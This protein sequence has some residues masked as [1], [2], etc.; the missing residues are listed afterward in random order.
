[1]PIL[2]YVQKLRFAGKS[3]NGVLLEEPNVDM[4]LLQR[5]YRSQ[6]LPNGKRMRMGD[7]IV[8]SD[9]LYPVEVIPVFGAVMDRRI[10]CHNSLEL[11]DL[12]YLNNF[13][14]KEMHH[15]FVYNFA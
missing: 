12:F 1:M 14:D 10:N 7:I 3:D 8:M 13:S 9:V 5:K 15:H 2:L 11:P 4:Y 6:I